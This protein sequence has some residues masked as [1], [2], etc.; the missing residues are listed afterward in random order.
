MA[1]ALFCRSRKKMPAIDL[2]RRKPATAAG[3]ISSFF[4]SKS[5]WE[6]LLGSPINRTPCEL[7]GTKSVPCEPARSFDV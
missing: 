3:M 5:A 1:L 6:L 7:T 2:S 4:R